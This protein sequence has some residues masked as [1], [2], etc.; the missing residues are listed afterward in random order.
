MCVYLP[1]IVR[2]GQK[3]CEGHSFFYGFSLTLIRCPTPDRL[4]HGGVQV[5][6]CAPLY[7]PCEPRLLQQAL[8]ETDGVITMRDEAEPLEGTAVRSHQTAAV[9]MRVSGPHPGVS[10]T[11]GP[12]ACL[13][14]VGMLSGP[15]T[16]DNL[17]SGLRPARSPVDLHTQCPQTPAHHRV[18][19]AD[20]RE[21]ILRARSSTMSTNNEHEGNVPAMDDAPPGIHR[22]YALSMSHV[23]QVACSSWITRTRPAGQQQVD[24]PRALPAW[25]LRPSGAASATRPCCALITGPLQHAHYR[26]HW[27]RVTTT[28]T[29]T[30]PLPHP[31]GAAAAS[32]KICQITSRKIC[33]ITYTM[34]KGASSWCHACAS[35]S[36]TARPAATAILPAPPSLATF[37]RVRVYALN[38]TAPLLSPLPPTPPFAL[39]LNHDPSND[40]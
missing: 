10:M 19:R 12:P 21:G 24:K 26:Y 27:C 38:I 31:S 20:P 30:A 3:R 33:Q 2:F 9:N 32:R 23:A 7:P 6:P 14:N 13:L 5:K 25:S 40:G 15:R 17:D 29:L 16:V 37:S 35:D 28:R 22:E 34:P 8:C 39:H 11:A 36:T 18:S 4:A 1:K